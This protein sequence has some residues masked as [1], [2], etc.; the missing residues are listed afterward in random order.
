MNKIK[1]MFAALMVTFLLFNMGSAMAVTE[2]N[3]GD[4]PW[5]FN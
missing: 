4:S 3:T 5:S 2:P 1:N